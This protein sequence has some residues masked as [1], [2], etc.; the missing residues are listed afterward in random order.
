MTSSITAT[1]IA[2]S[3]STFGRR[4]TTLQ[5]RYPRFIHSEFLTHRVFSRSSASSRAIP[6]AKM[7]EQVQHDP[8]LPVHWG[9]NQPG[10]QAHTEY[11][12][13]DSAKNA[14]VEAARAAA[15]HAQNLANLGLHKQ[16]VN[17]V[18]EP[19]QWMHTVVTATEW[20][21]FF[22]LR[23]HPDA[24]PEFQALACAIREA[25]AVS[26]PV[27]RVTGLQRID[28]WHLPYIS[29]EERENTRYA[30]LPKIS[31]ARCARVSYL[32]HDGSAPSIEEDLALF[33]RL[34]GSRPMHA[35]PCEH[36]ASA[37]SSLT[38]SRNFLGWLQY[39]GL[40]EEGFMR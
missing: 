28:S 36:Q 37:A 34:V 27:N 29:Q 33:E 38:C 32:K 25:M 10:M 20:A 15:S 30:L 7:I 23:C 16:I 11:S 19:F 14:W 17:R 6:V 8:A 1:V 18:L 12:D 26:I 9:L 35:S 39:R 21:N 3:I 4:I 2:D 40:Y 13:P 22:E 31:A 5:L 24:Q